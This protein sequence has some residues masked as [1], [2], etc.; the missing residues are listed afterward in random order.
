LLTDEIIFGQQSVA[1]LL[2][3]QQIPCGWNFW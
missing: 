2:E 3:T 1:D